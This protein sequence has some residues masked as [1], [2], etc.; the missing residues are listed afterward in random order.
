MQESELYKQIKSQMRALELLR[1][2]K[3][4]HNMELQNEKKQAEEEKTS[5]RIRRRTTARTAVQE[6]ISRSN[7]LLTL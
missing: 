7:W 1:Q 4:P 2:S 3:L 6:A 5:A